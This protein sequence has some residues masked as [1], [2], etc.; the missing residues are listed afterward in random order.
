MI[1]LSNCSVLFLW[2]SVFCFSPSRSEQRRSSH[3]GSDSSKSHHRQSSSKSK[4]YGSSSKSGHRSEERS[5]SS[6]AHSSHSSSVCWGCRSQ[7]PVGK[8][9][10]D[11]CFAKASRER[12]DSDQQLKALV[13]RVV[14]ES[15]KGI[16]AVRPVTPQ[17]EPPGSPVRETQL[18]DTW[19]S[20][21]PSHPSVVNSDS[22]SDEDNTCVGFDFALL[23][24]LVKAIRETL[25]W[26]DPTAVPPK[27]RKFFKQLKKERVNF[28]FFSELGEII[29]DEWSKVEKKNSM[30]TKISKLY[31]FREEEVKH[32][33]SAPLVDAAVMRLV[34]HVTLPL[35]D[36]V[37]FKDVLDRRIDADLRRV[38]LTA[39]MACKPAL[40]LAALSKAMEVWTDSVQDK[41][42]NISD[43]TA[44]NSPIQE[45][46]LASA[47][48]GEAS[49]DIIRLAARVMLSS[50]TAKRALWLRPWLAD[51][52]SKQVWC[53]IPYGG[54]SLFGNKLDEAITRA[55]GG[56]SGFLPQDRRL[57]GQRRT[58]PKRQYQ[59]RSREART[60]KPGREFSRSWKSRQ[61][62]FK[63]AAGSESKGERQPSKSF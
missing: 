61:S 8:S 17:A 36:T 21:V 54:S 33:E 1:V 48:L 14:K 26:E 63:K 37:S 59:D 56:K 3:K 18:Q 9:L 30:L 55:T 16:E 31:P 50:V 44:K 22:D 29:T 35:E 41:L 7:V 38:Y 28:P 47:F 53:R 24:P 27:Q 2:F 34:K 52:A 6:V 60:Y 46:R 43:D 15:L 45:L 5:H 13:E 57:Q 32:L 51:P 25:N 42:R 49:I 62:S 58:F 39:G 4:H 40:A 19:E 10:C 11:S 23:P 12:G 20:S